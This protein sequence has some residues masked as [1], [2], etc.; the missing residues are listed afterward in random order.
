MSIYPFKCPPY[1]YSQ[2]LS[3]PLAGVLSCSP[4]HGN[5]GFGRPDFQ[6]C[7]LACALWVYVC[8]SAFH[9]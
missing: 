9:I 1:H 4:W 3:G 6:N 8:Y 5:P 7:S 2:F